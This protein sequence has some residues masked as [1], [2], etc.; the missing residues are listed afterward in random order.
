[1]RAHSKWKRLQVDVSEY[2]V[3]HC[4]KQRPFVF[5]VDVPLVIIVRCQ[6]GQ[7]FPITPTF[8][9]HSVLCLTEQ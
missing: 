5:L 2:T 7:D 9:T 8:I 3:K 4:I 1:M 6:L